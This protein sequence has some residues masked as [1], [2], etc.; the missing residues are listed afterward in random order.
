[1]L[2]WLGLQIV[3]LLSFSTYSKGKVVDDM[4]KI[5]FYTH[6]LVNL[7]LLNIAHLGK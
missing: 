7:P 6:R 4:D 2:L 1:M 5:A 3:P